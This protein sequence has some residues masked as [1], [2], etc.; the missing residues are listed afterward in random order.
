M[1]SIE[2]VMVPDTVQLMVLRTAVKNT[3]SKR[4]SRDWRARS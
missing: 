2:S 4:A 1:P 3:P